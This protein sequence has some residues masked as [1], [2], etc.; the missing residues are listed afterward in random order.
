M[1]DCYAPLRMPIPD[2]APPVRIE[3]RRHLV[4]SL[5]LCAMMAVATL[6][7]LVARPAAAGDHAVATV[8]QAAAR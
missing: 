2:A 5:W 1:R 8:T 4:L 7:V 6:T 3:A